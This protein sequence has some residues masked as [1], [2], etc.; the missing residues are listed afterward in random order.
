MDSF[1]LCLVALLTVKNDKKVLFW[2]KNLNKK[3]LFLG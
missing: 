2:S 1:Y 3:L